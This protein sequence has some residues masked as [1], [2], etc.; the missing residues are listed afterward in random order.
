MYGARSECLIWSA[1]S[2]C[3]LEKEFCL[4]TVS[5]WVDQSSYYLGALPTVWT[6][7]LVLLLDLRKNCPHLSFD[8]CLSDGW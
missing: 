4:I 8:S 6:T 5:V 2:G 7:K 1:S 3:D